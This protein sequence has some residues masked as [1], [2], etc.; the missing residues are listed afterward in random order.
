MV[1]NKIYLSKCSVPSWKD[2]VL[3][4]CRVECS[5]MSY[6]VK[7]VDSVVQIFYI[8]SDFLHPLSIII[9]EGELKYIS[10]IVDLFIF[11]VLLALALY[12]SKLFIFIFWPSKFRIVK[13][14][15]W[16]HPFVIVEW[17]LSLLWIFFALKYSLLH[18]NLFT[19]ALLFDRSYFI[20]S[21]VTYLFLFIWSMFLVSST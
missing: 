2:C 1:Q 17:S 21:L 13:A 15:L 19:Q 3:C 9:D 10:I 7:L 8:L 5:I 14:S 4:C 20:L 16:S 6:Q 18:I 12:V 11:A